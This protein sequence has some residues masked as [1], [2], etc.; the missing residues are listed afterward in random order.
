MS[1]INK[2]TV[3]MIE[4]LQRCCA[5]TVQEISNTPC[6]FI[7]DMYYGRIYGSVSEAEWSEDHDWM[8]RRVTSPKG[9]PPVRSVWVECA[10]SYPGTR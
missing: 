4:T 10:L 7:N 5:V 8:V 6:V 1:K 2:V 9:K 3:P